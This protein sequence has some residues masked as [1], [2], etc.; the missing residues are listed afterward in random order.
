MAGIVI[1]EGQ[2]SKSIE[3]EFE[4]L[5]VNISTETLIVQYRESV[6]INSE[7]VTEGLKEYR[8]D[9]NKWFNS[10]IGETI[11]QLVNS[12]LEKM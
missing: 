11:K 5:V 8:A 4:G 2:V 7:V 10:Q 12:D 6:R 1:D 3:R 9:F